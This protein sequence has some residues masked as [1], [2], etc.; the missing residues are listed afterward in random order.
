[1]S[2]LYLTENAAKLS[3]SENRLVVTKEK[4]IL[5]SVPIETVEAVNVYG[6]GQITTQCIH[7][8]MK[9]EIPIVYYSQNGRFYG[10]LQ[11]YSHTEVLRQRKQAVFNKNP[12]ALELSKK[13]IDAKIRNQIV[14]LRR[15]A[16]ERQLDFKKE[17]RQ[18]HLLRE[19]ICGVKSINELMGY[20][21]NAARIYFDVLNKLVTPEFSF[22]G[23]T[24]RPPKDPF[25]AMLSLGYSILVNEVYGKLIAKGLN[26]CLGFMHQDR[27]NHPALASDLIEEW[28]MIIVDST[29]LSLITGHEILI[30]YFR[31]DDDGG[32]YLTQDGMRIYIRKLEMKFRQ[33]NRYLNYV[34]Q[35]MTFRRAIEFQVNAF[36]RVLDNND[37]NAYDPIRIR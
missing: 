3:V 28:R 37:I 12:M 30:D 34:K 19:K 26:P 25:N 17:Y 27:E 8:C 1:M 6:N 10:R 22:Q 16:Y 33:R 18:M 36:A 29:V 21:G 5:E 20:E 23:R 4:E 35:S 9:R 13:I 14:I 31:K 32:V 15:Y 11:S 7:E 24:R 2:Y